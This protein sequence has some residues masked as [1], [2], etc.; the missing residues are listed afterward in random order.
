MTHAGGA[1]RPVACAILTVSDTRRGVEDA[2]GNR[3]QELLERAGH[4]VVSRAWVKDEPAAIRS[5]AVL[6]LRRP[7][8]DVL[9]TTGGTGLALRDRT[10]EALAGLVQRWLPGFGELFRAYSTGQ[11][12]TA[13]WLSR[14]AA[15]IA[16]GR[17]VVMLPGSTAAVDLAAR[18]L[19]IPQLEHAVRMLGRFEPEE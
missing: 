8:V 17:L 1:P 13:S 6:I 18:R 5:A 12:G 4:R 2:S 10:P 11:V 7:P 16:R 3:L 9:I 19:L 15:G 14:A